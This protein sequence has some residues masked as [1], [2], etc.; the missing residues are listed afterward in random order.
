MHHTAF[1]YESFDDLLSSLAAE[2]AGDRAICV[3]RSWSDDLIVLFR[4]RPEH[5][6]RITADRLVQH[7][8]ASG[9][10]LMNGWP[11]NKQARP[12]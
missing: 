1:E 3:S 6:A 5:G 4:L 2:G 12:T 7:L 9:F 11:N 10:V 8:T